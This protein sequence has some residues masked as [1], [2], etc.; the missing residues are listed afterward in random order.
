VNLAENLDR[1][2]RARG[3]SAAVARGTEVSSFGEVDRWSRR[4][5]GFLAGHGVRPGDRVGLMLPDVVD[6][7]AL[8]YGIL[9]LGAVVVPLD[10]SLTGPVVAR[11]LQDSGARALVVGATCG[12]V[13]EP[14]ARSL[15]VVVWLVE[16]GGLLDLV[17]EAPSLDTIE[18]ME[19]A[20][21]AVIA[22]TAGTTGRARGAELTHGNLVRNCEVVVNDLVQLTSEDVVLGALPLHHVFAQTAG[23][24][25]AVRA[26]ACLVLLP[27]PDAGTTLETL[28]ERAVTVM[29]GEPATY[30]A[31]LEHLHDLQHTGDDLTRLRV[32][33]SGVA[34][35]PVEVLLGF[36]DAFGCLVLEV[37][38]LAEASPVASSNRRERR[39]VGSI[40]TPVTGVELRVVDEA[41]DEVGDGEL[42]EIVVRGHNVMRGY[43]GRPDLT[44]MT[45]VDGWLHTG[46]AGVKDEDGF[47]YVVDRTTELILR[48]GLKVY[49]REVEEVLREHRAVLDAHVLGVPHPGIGAEV[50]AFV[51]LRPGT[52]ATSSELRDFVR[53][54]VADHKYPRGIDIV[55]EIPTSST[56][57]SRPRAARLEDPA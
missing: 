57:R 11:R 33:L 56:G 52:T 28:R 1:T 27:R 18:P 31:V 4:V 41:G 19:A 17:G 10:P 37:Y 5:A 12:D 51:T 50:H 38:G 35:M 22:Y 25:A 21:V 34:A 29:Q 55:E 43:Q 8:Y 46:D 3:R 7:A 15:G 44:A 26:G 40:G 49:P 42:G 2:A 14:A 53:A 23:L 20:D 16:V 39:R 9:R 47:F 13:A 54:R 30:A 36:E 6:F 32:C 45:V 24:N 48:D